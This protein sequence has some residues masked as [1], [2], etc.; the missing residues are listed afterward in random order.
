MNHVVTALA[1]TKMEAGHLLIVSCKFFDFKM[2]LERY[3]VRPQEGCVLGC[4]G[5]LLCR[6]LIEEQLPRFH[7][8]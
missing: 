3:K 6:G 8:E 2:T 4:D 7:Q 5:A 1:E